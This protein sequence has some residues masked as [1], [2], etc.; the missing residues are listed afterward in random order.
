MLD[1]FGIGATRLAFMTRFVTGVF[2]VVEKELQRW[3]K[4]IEGA[5]DRELARQGLASIEK[6]RFH[7]QGG[8]FYALDGDRGKG[9]IPFIVALQTISDYLDNLCDRSGCLEMETFRQLHLAF[10]EALDPEAPVSD[11]Y[12]LF[13]YH[14]DNGYLDSLVEQ[15]RAVLRQRPAYSVVKSEVLRLAAF[16]CDLQTYKHTYL[17]LREDYLKN[18][19]AAYAERYPELKWWEFAAATGSTLGIFALVSAAADPQLTAEDAQQL[20]C[21]YF[22]W[23]C[24]MH[25]LLDYFIDQEED[26]VGGDLNFV[27][28]YPDNASQA[29][30]LGFFVSKALE[31]ASGL[32]EPYI[33]QTVVQGLP[34]FYLSDPKVEG[35]GL[36][37]AA[38]AILAVG[39]KDTQSIYKAC[40]LLRKLGSL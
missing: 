11:Y 23:I 6:K 34:A 39:G 33:H 1:T 3:Q 25:I 30:R 32:P 36:L 14:D 24:G 15:C 28:Y 40:R 37:E 7:A 26:R 35:Q 4:V 8:A 16:Y 29:E 9:L 18:W 27:A 38:N 12:L 22:P 10:T 2:P 13:P 20:A 5:G 21:C 31:C 19:F 17:P